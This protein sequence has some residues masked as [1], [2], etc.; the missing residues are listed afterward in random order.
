MGQ[1]FLGKWSG[2]RRRLLQA[3][4]TILLTRGV[5]AGFQDGFR[6]DKE[7]ILI[8]NGCRQW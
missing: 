4:L 6:N 8:Q 1:I 3:I 5:A 2:T 7:F